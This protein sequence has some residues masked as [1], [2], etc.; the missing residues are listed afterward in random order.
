MKRHCTGALGSPLS[1]LDRVHRQD[2]LGYDENPGRSLLDFDRG[3]RVVKCVAPYGAA[4]QLGDGRIFTIDKRFTSQTDHSVALI[5]MLSTDG[6]THTL[7]PTHF[8]G[9]LGVPPAD[10]DMTRLLKA[11]INRSYAKKIRRKTRSENV[12]LALMGEE[13]CRCGIV[14]PSDFERPMR[15]ARFPWYVKFELIRLSERFV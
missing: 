13:L 11:V 9:W 1:R 4:N 8:S 10:D 6:L 2:Q 7:S 5:R 12:L 15:D 3:E 14:S